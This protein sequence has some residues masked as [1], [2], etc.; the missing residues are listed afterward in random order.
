MKISK[1]QL[2]ELTDD[3][4]WKRGVDYSEGRN[5]LTLVKDK[6]TIVARVSGTRNY[7]VKLWMDGDELCGT[8][9]CPMGDE[10]VFCKHCVA[11]GLTYLDGEAGVGGREAGGQE[12]DGAGREITLVD[13]REYL[14]RQKTGTLVDI[15]AEQALEDDG[16]RERLI[17][18]AARSRQRK[19]DTKAFRK[20]I[21]QATNTRGFVDYHG[22]YGFSRRVENVVAGLADL[23]ADGCAEEAVELTE[24]A[25]KRAEEALGEMDDSDGYM[26]GIIERLEEL[27]HKACVE[28]RPETEK[29]A[30]R[31][32][33]WELAP[34]WDTFHG[35]V[36]T[37]ADV[38]GKKGLA[39]YRKL[40]EAQWK[41][42][43][44]LK[45]GQSDLAFDGHRYRLTS[46]MESLA[47]ADGD[48]E[49]LVA[50]KRRNLSLA[51]HYLEIAQTYR[52][53]GK[54]DQALV[55]AEKGLA[56]FPERTDGRLREFLADEYHSRRR[57]EEAVQLIW[58]N[59]F[60]HDGVENYAALKKHAERIK[61]WPRWRGQALELVRQRIE[62]I[63]AR[64]RGNR[65][66]W[67]GGP[68]HSTLVEIFLW[69]KDIDAAWQEAKRGGCSEYLWMKLA[70]LREKEHPADA[71]EVYKGQVEPIIAR[72]NRSAY[73]EA[74]GLIRKIGKLMKKLG[75]DDE[76]QHYKLYLAEKYKP[77]RTFVAMLKDLQ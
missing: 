75:R 29:L 52:E 59:F 21:A 27:H 56:A 51:Y 5:V 76:F 11:V 6:G 57:H 14:S 61:Q 13:V 24:Y 17:M 3:G 50:V 39:V 68:D 62:T 70:K 60:E 19:V 69:E 54:S 20:V 77:K 44:E 41:N 2:K 23:L 46:I 67:D 65:P 36:E 49:A 35:A 42:V 28:A 64:A 38:L 15:I 48:I 33:E 53:A 73:R 74:M 16:L 47:R 58:A 31:R 66:D 12:A 43:P 26:G 45:P 71:V 34:H 4:S 30:R 8:C 40:A 18:K 25:L 72:T 22:A 37:Y 9:D 1:A 32:F 10:G 63:K 7:N 55:W